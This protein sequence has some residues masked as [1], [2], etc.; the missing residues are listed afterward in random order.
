MLK[1][2]EKQQQQRAAS[3]P[4]SFEINLY[5]GHK[6][7]QPREREKQKHIEWDIKRNHKMDLLSSDHP[8]FN[9]LNFARRSTK[10]LNK[11]NIANK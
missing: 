11:A 4:V 10:H 8:K 5:F 6:I 9:R 2:T 7:G 1:N 3:V